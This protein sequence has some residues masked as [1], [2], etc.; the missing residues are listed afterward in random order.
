MKTK[1]LN[2]IQKELNLKSPIKQLE[3]NGKTIIVELKKG[4]TATIEHMGNSHLFTLDDGTHDF[5][6]APKR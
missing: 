1:L 5:S 2:Y 6:K 3:N 4:I